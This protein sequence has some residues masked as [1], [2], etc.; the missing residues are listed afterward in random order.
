ME[1]P[2]NYSNLQLST[3]ISEDEESTTKDNSEKGSVSWTERKLSPT[4]SE[5]DLSAGPQHYLLEVSINGII[6]SHGTVDYFLSS[7]NLS[8]Y[9]DV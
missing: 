4:A 7:K 2:L 5:A 6:Y 9:K 3:S 1:T 8:G